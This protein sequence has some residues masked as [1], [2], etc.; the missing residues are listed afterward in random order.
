MH[1]KLGIEGV[2]PVGSRCS[3]I[4]ICELRD[5]R[6]IVHSKTSLPVIASSTVLE[7]ST[8]RMMI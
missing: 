8:S 4:Y 6:I 7:Y 2:C 5:N 1:E 3:V